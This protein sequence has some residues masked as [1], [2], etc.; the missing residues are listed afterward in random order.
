MATEKFLSLKGFRR[1]W[2]KIKAALDN[3]SDVD[4]AHSGYLTTSAA[5]NTYATLT[6][7]NA[8]SDSLSDYATKEDIANV[9]IYRG[10]VTFY[11]A[12]PSTGLNAGDVYNVEDTGKNY[13]WTGT[14]WDDLGGSFDVDI[15]SIT[16]TEIDAICV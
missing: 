3:K 1:V 7:V 9:Y 10:T 5:S 6:Q 13:A 16:D 11:E 12:L 2:N 4:H 14:E 15:E 8:I